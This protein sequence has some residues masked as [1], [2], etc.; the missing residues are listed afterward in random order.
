MI[1]SNTP[2][3]THSAAQP[4]ETIAK[5]IFKTDSSGRSAVAVGGVCFILMAC[6]AF[7]L[8]RRRNNLDIS[9]L[10]STKNDLSDNHLQYS[11]DSV[12]AISS[13][14]VDRAGAAKC[15]KNKVVDDVDLEEGRRDP[16]SVYNK[17]MVGNINNI[18]AVMDMTDAIHVPKMFT[19][20][21]E[22]V[23]N[24]D[25]DDKKSVDSVEVT[26]KA[27]KP[28]RV[29]SRL[30][31][32]FSPMKEFSIKMKERKRRS[33]TA[34]YQ[35]SRSMA[36][37]DLPST[38]SG[39]NS[40]SEDS[41]SRTSE[42]KSISSVKNEDMQ[43]PDEVHDVE[44]PCESFAESDT[45]DA[46]AISL[47]HSAEESSS[48]TTPY[49]ADVSIGS[50]VQFTYEEELLNSGRYGDGFS[51]R[52]VYFDP[53]N[54]LYECRVPTGHLGISVDSTQLGLRVQ[55]IN[56][57]SPLYNI[58]SAGDV[59]IGV[60][61]VDVVGLESFVFWELVARRASKHHDCCLVI[62]KI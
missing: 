13:D 38:H 49:Q 43:S 37:L 40:D 55:K 26:P 9:G 15:S 58:V 10:Q 33:L 6:T 24:P 35:K 29:I 4:K 1:P 17:L 36:C 48:V 11:S 18:M 8:R 41:A 61:D 47:H 50:S 34:D 28:V 14:S 51:F 16:N 27:C 57:T 45:S 56:P 3:P 54:E 60:N 21:K 59:I 42:Y 22:K 53:E 39:S 12:V 19:R 52:D 5:V 62:M 7:H 30:S 25:A 20:Q 46:I 32:M 23:S 44:E 31:P 2:T